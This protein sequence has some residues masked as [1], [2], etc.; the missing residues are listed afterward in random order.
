M[1]LH[2]ITSK[3]FVG[4]AVD[5]FEAVHRNNNCYY[6]IG[7]SMT[8][9]ESVPPDT[10]IR[11]IFRNSKEYNALVKNLGSY[12]ALILHS[13]HPSMFRFVLDAPPGLPIAW[14]FFGQEIYNTFR[15]FRLKVLLPET[16]KYF[17]ATTDFYLELIKPLY[18]KLIGKKTNESYVRDCLK[19]INFFATPQEKTYQFLYDQGMTKARF[20]DFS[21]YSIEESVGKELLEKKVSGNAIL[22]GNSSSLTN[23]Y[24]DTFDL[25]SRSGID[26]KD[27]VVP[28]SYGDFRLGKRVKKLGYKKFGDRFHPISDF[29]PRAEYNR[30]MLGCSFVIMNHLRPQAR[31]NIVTALW[32]GAKVFMN[33]E[34]LFYHDFIEKGFIVFPVSDIEEKRGEAFQKI[35]IEEVEKNRKILSELYSYDKVLIRTR[36]LVDLLKE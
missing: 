22:V 17:R 25:L 11:F 19:R 4:Y 34:N 18:R 9:K 8:D 24:F 21:Y 10:N 14:I 30:L 13:L 33:K 6:F 27:I 3:I 26:N 1:I 23:N 15:R 2:L 7:S 28:L 16:R 20:V 36:Q 29:L 5:Q 35:T 32:L 12:D 31:G